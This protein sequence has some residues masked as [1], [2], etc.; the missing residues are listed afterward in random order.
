VNYADSTGSAQNP[1]EDEASSPCLRRDEQCPWCGSDNLC[2]VAKGTLYKGPCW[3]EAFQLPDPLL[4]TLAADRV[5]PACLCRA[6]LETIDRLASEMSDPDAILFEAKRI[7][8]LKPDYYVDPSGKVVF[9]QWYLLK[10]GALGQ[11]GSD[12]KGP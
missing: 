12:Q 11:N 3:C 1:P 6:C 9:T 7:A 10:R 2:R 4:R 5:E 8:A